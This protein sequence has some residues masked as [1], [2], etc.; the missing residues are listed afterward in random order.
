[1]K[2]NGIEKYEENVNI[3]RGTERAVTSLAAPL[4]RIQNLQ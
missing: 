4:Q 3:V 2:S 1:V